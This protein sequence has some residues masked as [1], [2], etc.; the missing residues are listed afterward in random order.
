MM[1]ALVQ[2]HIVFA[3]LTLFLLIIRGAMQFAGKDW[4]AKKLLKILPHLSDTVLLVSGLVL[5]FIYGFEI[6]MVEKLLCF[7]V[8]ALGAAKFFSKKTQQA[9]AFD[10]ILALAALLI[11]MWLGYRH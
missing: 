1:S 7:V 4:R 2:L 6:W 10:F 3:F 8:Y 9:R 5:A 11:A